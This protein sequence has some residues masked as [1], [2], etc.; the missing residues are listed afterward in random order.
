LYPART[1]DPGDVRATAGIS[2]RLASGGA[3]EALAA[4]Q[5]IGASGAP[6][7]DSPGS[8][9]EAYVQGALV[10]ASVSP[11]A[12]P[13]V[14]G[15]VG[16]GAHLEG[17]LAY[18]GRG[19]RIDIRHSVDIP[20]ARG[21]AASAGLGVSGAFYGRSASTPL[22][23]VDLSRLRGAGADV[24]LIV[25]W[26]SALGLYRVWGGARGGYER[27][28]ID[29]VSS[30]GKSATLAP[31]VVPLASDRWYVGGLVGMAVGFRRV[32]LAMELELSYVNVAGTFNGVRAQVEGVAFTPA[33]GLWISF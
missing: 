21:V 10:A 9:P 5:A 30:E 24:P 6:V 33:G 4:A 23:A 25:G 16:L 32:H 19:A 22:P 28:E 3:E 20:G 13:M 15:R 26:E 1:L 29:V 18:T 2:Y 11:G 7:V 27:A 12:A 31:P 8:T 14:A 17:G